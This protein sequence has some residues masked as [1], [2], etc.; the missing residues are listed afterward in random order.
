MALHIDLLLTYTLGKHLKGG[1]KNL[2]LLLMCDIFQNFESIFVALYNNIHM[3]SC[4]D[5]Q[6]YQIY[7]VVGHADLG[8]PYYTVHRQGQAQLAQGLTQPNPKR[9]RVWP[10]FLWP[11]LT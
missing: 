1:E 4:K 2:S 9:A 7:K 11:G 6:Y 5:V 3:T 8:W 10:V